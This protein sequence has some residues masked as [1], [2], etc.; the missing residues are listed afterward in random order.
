MGKISEEQ[1][2]GMQNVFLD[3]MGSEPFYSS[4]EDLKVRN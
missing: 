1:K 2:N 4:R 3:N